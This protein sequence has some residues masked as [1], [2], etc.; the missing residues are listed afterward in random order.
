VNMFLGQ[1]RIFITK[2]HINLIPV[3]PNSSFGVLSRG[4][5]IEKR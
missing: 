3:V 4:S 5:Q 2:N 1:L